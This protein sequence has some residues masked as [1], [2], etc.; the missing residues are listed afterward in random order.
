MK[1]LMHGSTLII[2]SN[3][4]SLLKGNS[5]HTLLIINQYQCKKTILLEKQCLQSHS[6]NIGEGG[7]APIPPR[8]LRH[9]KLMF[10][11]GLLSSSWETE[12]SKT[13]ISSSGLTLW[14]DCPQEVWWRKGQ[15]VELSF[16]VRRLDLNTWHRDVIFLKCYSTFSG[17]SIGLNC[18]Y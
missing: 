8:T 2:Q 7:Q 17:C 11:L 12:S 13:H 10:I 16:S 1:K 18:A 14:L 9:C 6:Q 15:R 5:F 4:I 3:Q